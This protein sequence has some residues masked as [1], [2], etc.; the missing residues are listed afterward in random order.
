MFAVYAERAGEKVNRRTPTGITPYEEG[1]VLIKV[2]DCLFEAAKDLEETK[3]Q[4]ARIL[5]DFAL[6]VGSIFNRHRS[7]GFDLRSMEDEQDG[8]K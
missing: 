6:N 3:P 1:Q 8:K 2:S 5:R 4:W 7:H